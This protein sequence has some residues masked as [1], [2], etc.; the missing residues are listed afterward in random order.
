[1]PRNTR[2]QIV[3]REEDIERVA[4][5]QEYSELEDELHAA[6]QVQADVQPAVDATDQVGEGEG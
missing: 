6:W 3:G 5:E 1:M 4:R 2:K